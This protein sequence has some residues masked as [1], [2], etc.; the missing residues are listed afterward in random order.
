[1][2]F[3]TWSIRN[4]V[5]VIVLFIGLTVAGLISFPKL[6]V[7][8]RPDIEFPTITVS[9]GYA[10]VAPTQMESEITRKVED[11]VAT[12]AGIEQMTS[13]VNEGS[14]TTSI[15]FRFGTD[16][17]Q[18]LDDVRDALTRIRQDLPLDANEPIV[19]RNTT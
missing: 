5:P 16:M 3:V 18:A 11:A 6:G 8:D 17:S 19:S 10:G 1:M 7:Q 13:T 14:S 2:N 15:E 4:P 12:I 9:V